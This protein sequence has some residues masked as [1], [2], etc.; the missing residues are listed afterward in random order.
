MVWRGITFLGRG[1]RGLCISLYQDILPVTAF[2]SPSHSI[3]TF[4]S[5]PFFFSFLKF[6]C[7]SAVQNILSSS[8]LSK[9]TGIKI[10]RNV[11]LPVVLCGCETLLL[12]LREGHRLRGFENRV[13]RGIFGPKRGKM[14]GE[15]RKLLNE[16]LNDQYC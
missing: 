6:M 2:L 13:L 5:Y 4:P 12:T 15:W 9:N 3:L 10:Y 7:S 8:L 16:E 1:M 11:I 14:T